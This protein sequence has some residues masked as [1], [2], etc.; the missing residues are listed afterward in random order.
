MI[1][2][3]AIKQIETLGDISFIKCLS[4][5]IVKKAISRSNI[6]IIIGNQN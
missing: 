4:W 2:I 5:E 6:K 1:G 3:Q